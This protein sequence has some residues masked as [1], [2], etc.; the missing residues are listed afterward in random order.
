MPIPYEYKID[1]NQIVSKISGILHSEEIAE[2]F[3]DLNNELSLSTDFIGIV[4]FNDAD[5]LVLKYTDLKILSDLFQSLTDK[6]HLIT[7]FYAYNSHAQ[8][9][10]GMMI[11]L[12]QTMK[13]NVLVCKNESELELNKSILKNDSCQP[14]HGPDSI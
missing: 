2:Y 13:I 10:L 11:P 9:M 1:S 8:G 12:F 4:D 7:L 6:G 5:D 14:K 3:K